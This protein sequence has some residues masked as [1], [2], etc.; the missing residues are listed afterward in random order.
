MLIVVGLL[1]LQLPD[2]AWEGRLAVDEGGLVSSEPLPEG[3]WG[4]SDVL[5]SGASA[6]H[7]APVDKDGGLALPI[8]QAGLRP[9]VAALGLHVGRW[10]S[11][12]LVVPRDYPGH[13]G[14]A[15]VSDLNSASV[16]V[17][18]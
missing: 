11:H 15:A 9:T 16:K 17:L 18:A 10:S 1:I 4:E 14:H 2:V 6:L 13:V 7:S 5:L 12:L 8:Q 3:V